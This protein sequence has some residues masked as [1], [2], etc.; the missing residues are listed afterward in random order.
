MNEEN[1]AG[2]ITQ[3]WNNIEK[4]Y[5]EYSKNFP[6]LIFHDDKKIEFDL[7]F[8][9]SYETVMKR[10]MTKKTTILD[11]HKQAA[12]LI[13]CFLKTNIIE[14]PLDDQNKISIVPQLI[15]LNL[16][17]SYMLVC[18]ND[19]LEKHDI[20]KRIEK[21]YMPIAT[22]CDTP[23]PEILCRILYQEQ[24]EQ[25]M[26]FNILELSDRLFLLEYINLLQHGIEPH[27]LKENSSKN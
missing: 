24:H 6:T 17:L 3:S 1:I 10:F 4:E 23:Y 5:R 7:L 20:K 12:L 18:L 26:D 21:Y 11:S 27:L 14:H 2:L 9:K 19:R 22:A 25:D 16:G 13:I 8:K 15:A